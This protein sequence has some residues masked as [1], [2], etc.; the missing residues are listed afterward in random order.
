MSSWL[1]PDTHSP[2]ILSAY[3]QRVP[4]IM[5]MCPFEIGSR[6]PLPLC[7]SPL[8]EFLFG[9]NLKSQGQSMWISEDLTVRSII[10]AMI[11]HRPRGGLSHST[12][13]LP[14]LSVL[15][16]RWPQMALRP[17][18][19]DSPP[20]PFSQ[21]S[22]PPARPPCWGRRQP[23]KGEGENHSFPPQAITLPSISDM[24]QCHLLAPPLDM[25]PL[26]HAHY[27]EV[28][29]LATLSTKQRCW[30]TCCYILRDRHIVATP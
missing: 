5:V 13:G 7:S 8:L 26:W 30:L 11:V 6:L 17:D 3:A 9:D 22:R 24:S 25:N 15:S 29:V 27:V 10:K 23:L 2:S 20:L 16:E 14:R 12:L 1:P 21:T 19:Q 4:A 28:L 18:R